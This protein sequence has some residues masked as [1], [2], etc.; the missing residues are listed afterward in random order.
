MNL[1][2]SANFR[3]MAKRA[4][5]RNPELQQ[6]IK[7]TLKLLAEDPFYPKLRS[8]KLEGDLSSLWACTLDY[9]NRNYNIFLKDQRMIITL[10]NGMVVGS[11]KIRYLDF[12]KIKEMLIFM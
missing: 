10:K 7:D 6:R 9:D 2:W 5:Q 3:R 11:L 12:S 8:H 1:V 4:T